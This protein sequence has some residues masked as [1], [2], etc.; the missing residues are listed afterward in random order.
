VNVGTLALI[1]FTNRPLLFLGCSLDKDRTVTV[2]KEIHNRLP[3]PT[4]Y[5][6]MEA[7]YSLPRWDASS[8]PGLIFERITSVTFE[9]GLRSGRRR[10]PRGGR[11]RLPGQVAFS[12]VGEPLLW[13]LN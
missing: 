7:L 3:T 10:R 8:I 4:H 5:A 2:L 12:R 6:V 11:K 13:Q 1:N 9:P